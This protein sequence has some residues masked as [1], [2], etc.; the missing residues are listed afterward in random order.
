MG[1]LLDAVVE[2]LNQRG[3]PY[4][5][6]PGHDTLHFP[7]QGDDE[8]WQCFAHAW[9]DQHRLAVYSVCP[10]NLPEERRQA[11]A[12]LVVRVD[13]GLIIG[14]FE[15]DLDDGQ[16]RYKTS[17][18]V[19]GARLEAPLVQQLV[20]AN[21]NAMNAYLP[22]FTAIVDADTSV[23]DALARQGSRAQDRSGGG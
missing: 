1:A 10:F 11:A 9:E 18:D 7:F 17:I 2:F 13:Y 8:R 20:F 23:K 22:A 12:E 4:D 14:N 21:L 16:V 6:G 3:W 5:E 15:L 19:Q